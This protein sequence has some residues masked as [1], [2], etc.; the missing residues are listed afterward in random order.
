MTLE[1]L[2]RRAFEMRIKNRN[3]PLGRP[4]LRW[5]DQ[6]R[7]DLQAKG[8]EWTTVMNE[9]CWEDRDIWKRLSL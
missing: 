9:K 4:E 5:I 7:E 1:R 8:V 3:Q 6:L 2:T